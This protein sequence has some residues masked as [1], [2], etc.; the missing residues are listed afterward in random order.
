MD[1]IL[2]KIIIATGGTG[3]HVIPAYNLAKHFNDRKINVE[4][5]SDKR[6]I[7]Y[8][9]EI[10]DIK[11]S[12][13]FTSPIIKKNIFTF[14]YSILII[15]F[16]V[17]RSFFHLTLNRPSLIFGM[18]GYSSFPICIAAKILNIPFVLYES[19]L[20]IGKA[21]K[22]LSSYATKIFVSHKELEG[23]QE[24]FQN[25]TI[26]IGNIIRKEII[27]YQ[28]RKIILKKEGKIRIL[29]LG[30]SQA[31][32]VFA[33]KLPEI[34]KLCKNSKIDLEVFQQCLP[35]QNIS[36]RTMYETNKIKYEIFNYTQNILE[37]FLKTDLAITRSG[38][39]M[40]TELINMR[41][42]FISV[43]LPSSADD[44]QLKNAIFYKKRGFCYL[45]EEKDLQLKLFKLLK[46]INKDNSL[47]N[48]IIDAQNQYS[49]KSV[50]ENI[51]KEIKNI[52]DEKY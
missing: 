8:I 1:R 49:D 2:K 43:P 15:L 13:I 48:K 41:V 42:P 46:E 45:I 27:N 36:L 38:S 40:S 47:L 5:I 9:K 16:S 39:S 23:M 10:K 32:K 21:N 17:I 25:K 22:Y 44:H 35:E 33:E 31:A 28:N 14:F 51:D 4:V 19:N 52:I 50:Y 24:I 12:Q 30:G 7:K 34:F 11:L 3:G 29:V 26:Q 20:L 6:G 37:Y 18:G